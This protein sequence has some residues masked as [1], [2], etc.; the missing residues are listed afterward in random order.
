[1]SMKKIMIVLAAAALL[2]SSCGSY[3]ATGAYTGSQFGHVLGSAIGGLAGG[4]RGHELGS[5]VGTVGGAAVG[6][7]IGRSAD[8]RQEERVAERQQA[9]RAQQARQR[10]AAAAASGQYDNGQY[11]NGQYDNSGYDP[12]MQGDDRISFDPVDGFNSTGTTDSYA[13]TSQLPT[14]RQGY[15]ATS[16]PALVVRNAGVYEDQRDGVLTRGEAAKVIFEIV[17]T[18]SQPVYDVFPLVE[19]ATGN[20]HVHISP[21]LRIESIAPHQAVRYTASLVADRGLRNGQ[22]AVR[23]G[24]AQGN[25]VIS[26]QTRQFTVTTAKRAATAR[27]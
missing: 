18:S 12:Q 20:K 7:A 1:M 4:W 10:Q 19:E 17:N 14:L 21:N 5:I 8:R 15:A 25:S 22:I 11:G 6:A 16:G 26:S 2:L 23:V 13:G 24:V 9:R 3:E 27:R